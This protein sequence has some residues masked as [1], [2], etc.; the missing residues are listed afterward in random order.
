MKLLLYG[1][2]YNSVSSFEKDYLV[3][4][5]FG[6]TE[7]LLAIKKLVGVEETLILATSE[8]TE[9]YLNV[10]ENYFSHGDF[11]RYLTMFY[12]K[13][14]AEIISDSYSL[15][16]KEVVR[17]LLKISSVENQNMHSPF[18]SIT[19]FETAINYAIAADSIGLALKNLF[20]EV[21][22]YSINIKLDDKIIPNYSH[23][24]FDIIETFSLNWENYRW[25][26]I[27]FE[28]VTSDLLDLMKILVHKGFTNLY[29]INRNNTNLIHIN[30]VNCTA[31]MFD[32]TNSRPI[33]S[34]VTQVSLNFHLATADAFISSG[35]SLD[36][37]CSIYSC[38]EIKL[39]QQNKSSKFFISV[40]TEL[41]VTIVKMQSPCYKHVENW[42]TKSTHNMAINKE[43]DK[44]IEE[45]FQK[46]S[47][48]LWN[49][50]EKFTY[51]PVQINEIC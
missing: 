22:S 40:D 11:L 37:F 3:M 39:I 44:Y 8:R 20:K 45:T 51:T 48:D 46:S 38:E 41:N 5:K 6:V 16:N 24:F 34:E 35:S 36:E 12:K 27:V 42:V 47:T 21:I 19:Q 50:Y 49:N 23:P 26:K 14:M 17:H 30:E 29:Y 10:D 25:K 43:A 33:L 32:P 9:Y 31:K 2:G 4:N 13:D 7:Q 18:E 28:N 15:F 1:V